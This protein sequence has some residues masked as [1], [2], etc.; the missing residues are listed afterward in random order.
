MSETR[1]K[2]GDLALHFAPCLAGR[3]SFPLLLSHVILVV[4]ANSCL[5]NYLWDVGNIMQTILLAKPR[6]FFCSLS[7]FDIN[8]S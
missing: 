7:W 1:L 6:T 4:L 8:A 2:S 5:A 3:F